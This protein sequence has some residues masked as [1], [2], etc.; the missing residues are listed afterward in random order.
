MA[1]KQ[2]KLKKGAKRKPLA[3]A[4]KSSSQFSAAAAAKRAKAGAPESVASAKGK[5][6]GKG[7]DGTSLFENV[8]TKRKFDII[9]RKR[10]SE[11]HRVGLSR[12]AAIDKRKKTILQEFKSRGKANVFLD[13]RFGEKDEGLAEEDKAILRFQRERQAQWQKRSK[14]MLPD[15]DEEAILTHGGTALSNLEDD[16][17]VD[18]DEDEDEELE[19]ELVRDFHF[20]GDSANEHVRAGDDQNEK[21]PKSKKEIME[22]IIAKS[23]L[24]KAQKAKEK[25]EDAE[26]KDQLDK[27]FSELAQSQALISLVRPKK[28]TAVK[29][30]ID[31]T[32][33]GNQEKADDFDKLVKEMGM[34]MRAHASD[35]LKTD[36]E[37]AEEEKARLE[38][39]EE[40][41]KKRMLDEE[42]SE[43]S[44]SEEADHTRLSRKTK[45]QRLEISGDDLGENFLIDDDH[46]KKGWVDEV[47][48]RKEDEEEDSSS[49]E[50]EEMSSNSGSGEDDG[51][52]SP[53]DREIS[54]EGVLHDDAWEESDDDK[55]TSSLRTMQEHSLVQ[56]VEGKAL[57]TEAQVDTANEFKHPHSE[58][59]IPFVIEAPKRLEDLKSLV[60]G[61]SISDLLVVIQRI[62]TCNSIR[63]AAENRK[64]MQVFYGILLQYFAS[65][66][67]GKV[68][69]LDRLNALVKPLIEMSSE[70]PYF[71][72]VCGREWIIRMREQFI[73]K[74]RNPGVDGPWPSRRNLAL[75]RLWSLT[76]P[77]S[78]FRHVVL[79]PCT[80]LMAEYLMRC[81]VKFSRDLAVGTFICALLLSIMRP[82]RRLCPEG[83]SFLYAALIS[84]L[85]KKMISSKRVKFSGCGS[86]MLELVASQPWLCL[87]SDCSTLSS[88]EEMDFDYVMTEDKDASYFD[89]DGYRLLVISCVLGTL[90][91]FS[92]I[93]EDISCYPELFDPFV[94]VL[95]NLAVNRFFPQAMHASITRLLGQIRENIIKTEML[96]Q[97]LRMRAKKPAPIKQ[98]NPKFEENFVQGRNYDPDRERAEG[99]KLQRLIKQE[100]KGAAREL[101]KDNYFLQAEKAKEKALADEQREEKYRKAM[102][103]LQGQEASFKSGQLGKG[104]GRGTRK[105]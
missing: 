3:T 44:G 17:F 27:Q 81:P 55:Q 87:Q 64:K 76:F 78:D 68:P 92:H 53:S 22:E 73:E 70:T 40:K 93:Y 21:K 8:W 24:Y 4:A 80:L 71:A 59:Q 58:S 47:L 10:K 91:G 79:T 16:L 1:S 23:K 65:V 95:Q 74:L 90:E 86:F 19:E 69:A 38:E 28:F 62:R 98:F 49:E 30:T 63:L 72:A 54:E 13:H 42:F 25:E 104:K 102:A 97:P 9:G 26:L 101:R 67:G 12:S 52:L 57:N 96:R 32:D 83:L 33:A 61:R 35:R 2:N 34:E 5:K 82:T 88:I 100:A 39:L 36:E 43:D 31:V 51:D 85:S 103:F 99:K 29:A 6:L 60:D 89:S 15:E 56:G 66:G 37:I 14:F 20:G 48:A 84:A 41:R 50:D 18:D 75:L 45:R 77:P 46:P 7:G 105:R 11:G 94:A